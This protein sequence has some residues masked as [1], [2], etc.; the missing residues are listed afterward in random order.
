MKRI[1]VRASKAPF[2][3][4]HQGPIPAWAMRRVFE[5]HRFEGTKNYGNLVFAHSAF[6]ALSAPTNELDIDR[7]QLSLS[8]DFAAEAERINA[9]YDAFVIPLCNS[10]RVPYKRTL[11]RIAKNLQMLNI[12]CIV[13]GVG[14]QL[15]LGGD[16]AELDS[17]RD[18]AKAVVSA[19]LERSQ[20]IGV[21]GEITRDYLIHL[22]FP[23]DK[24][25]VIGCPSIFY[26]GARMNVEKGE[27]GPVA[28]NLT[29]MDD[30]RIMPFLKYFERHPE[31]ATYVPQERH[32]MSKMASYTTGTVPVL[33]PQHPA[34]A[35]LR[36]GNVAFLTD[37]VPWM[38]FLR[39]QSFAIGTRIHGNITAIISGAPGHVIAHDTRTLELSRYNDI[40][41]TPIN[42]LAGFDL[43]KTFDRSNYEALNRNHA[44]RTRVYADFLERN[45][46]D[47]ILYDNV[48]LDA[49]EL[50]VRTAVSTAK[51]PTIDY[52]F[53]C[54]QFIRRQAAR[55]GF[56]KR[57][58]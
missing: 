3:V 21:R 9:S 11:A 17:I 33:S 48:A 16:F 55:V 23:P 38:D 53:R 25:V 42:E 40:P 49:H 18:E 51:L 10:F 45:G 47:H 7:Y 36:A 29:P 54:R 15:T 39:K 13:T 37:L 31:N 22:G 52:K 27:L 26:N 46:L 43:A 20:S 8:D 4:L 5:A 14:A 56:T 1:L 32:L 6:K 44:A 50:R 30:A 12:P 41:H 2:D 24:V 28:V 58:R 19:V 35:L 57:A 34:S